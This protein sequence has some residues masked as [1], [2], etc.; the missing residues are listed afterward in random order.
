MPTELA[1]SELNQH[2]ARDLE[3][4]IALRTW[5][6]LRGL[7]VEVGGERVTVR[8]FAPSYYVKQLAIQACME[9]AGA[10]RLPR[11]DVSIVVREPSLLPAS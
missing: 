10:T 3:R 7:V 2:L 5:G 4:L 9:A 8:G 6:R 1:D 11:L